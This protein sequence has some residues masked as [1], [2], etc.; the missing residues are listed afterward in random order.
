MSFLKICLSLVTKSSFGA[1]FLEN[2]TETEQMKKKIGFQLANYW[3]FN[4]LAWVFWELLLEFF[5]IHLE[6][7]RN[8]QKKPDICFI[9]AKERPPFSQPREQISFNPWISTF[10]LPPT[11]KMFLF[12]SK[13]HYNNYLLTH[14]SIVW[15]VK[16]LLLIHTT[17]ESTVPL[18]LKVN[19]W[20]SYTTIF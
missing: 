14:D 15:N 16:P 6:F 8:V 5:G 18:Y 11:F 20:S 13:S 17:A 4:K 3:V 19:I 1:I 2:F 9:L 10:S 12:L 7:F